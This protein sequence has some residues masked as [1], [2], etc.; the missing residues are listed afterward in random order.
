MNHHISFLYPFSSLFSIHPPPFQICS[1]CDSIHTS[2]FSHES[3]VGMRLRA[4]FLATSDCSNPAE[5][6]SLASPFQSLSSV[7]RYLSFPSSPRRQ[8][9][10]HSPATHCPRWSGVKVRRWSVL[11]LDLSFFLTI[12]WEGDLI[13]LNDYWWPSKYL[14]GKME[15]KSCCEVRGR[16][17]HN[18]TCSPFLLTISS[19][20]LF[21]IPHHFRHGRERDS[22]AITLL[23]DAIHGF[24][25]SCSS[26]S[27]ETS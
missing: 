4:A 26:N 14:T 15:W 11:S 18:S 16:R 1:W 7:K 22:M 3:M 17:P 10:R 9:I 13:T 21:S 25:W 19:L 6:G 2:R 27:Q 20:S 23:V 12:I 24:R 5:C 8:S